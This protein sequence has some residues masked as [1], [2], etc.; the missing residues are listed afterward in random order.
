V[1]RGGTPVGYAGSGT[2]GPD[3]YSPGQLSQAAHVRHFA[4]G[5]IL[6]RYKIICFCFGT[7]L[8]KGEFETPGANYALAMPSWRNVSTVQPTQPGPSSLR[9]AKL[10]EERY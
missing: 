9:K 1:P 7:S 4:A 10:T 3:L 2:T 6:Q 5:S 8:F